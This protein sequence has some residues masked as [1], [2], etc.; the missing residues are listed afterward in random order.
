MFEPGHWHEDGEQ[1]DFFLED[2]R[3]TEPLDR[4]VAYQDLAAATT[5]RTLPELLSPARVSRTLASRLGDDSQNRTDVGI[6]VAIAS[7]GLSI[8][9]AEV[10]WLPLGQTWPRRRLIELD[11]LAAR[12]PHPAGRTV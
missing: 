12:T 9:P 7:S 10:A 1:V 11:S 5:K 2:D 8:N 4:L 3:G 6:W